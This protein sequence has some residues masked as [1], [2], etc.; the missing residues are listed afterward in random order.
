MLDSFIKA[1]YGPLSRYLALYTGISSEMA[2]WTDPSNIC[3]KGEQKSLR[4]QMSVCLPWDNIVPLRNSR[5]VTANT[6]HWY[7][8]ESSKVLD[9]RMA[10]QGF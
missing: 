7:C 10:K 9:M 2:M 6:F 4:G 5:P 3:D 8:L 1:Q